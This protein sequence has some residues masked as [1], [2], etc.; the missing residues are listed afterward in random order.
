MQCTIG[1]IALFV[2]VN[3]ETCVHIVLER[4]AHSECDSL[5]YLYK[6]EALF[7][8]HVSTCGFKLPRTCPASGS[9]DLTTP[10]SPKH[11]SGLTRTSRVTYVWPSHIPYPMRPQ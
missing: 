11:C 1:L 7:E 6:E 10:T 2:L 5:W 4:L 8:P 9:S 3:N